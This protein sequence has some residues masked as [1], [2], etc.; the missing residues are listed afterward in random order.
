LDPN[1]ST[2]STYQIN[3][4][5]GDPGTGTE[6][7]KATSAVNWSM[8]QGLTIPGITS[9]SKDAQGHITNVTIKDYVIP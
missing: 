2:S 9:L 1:D 7:A 3:I 4:T 8:G 5:H 6:V